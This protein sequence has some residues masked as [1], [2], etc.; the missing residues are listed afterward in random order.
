VA[1]DH[2]SLGTS[3]TVPPGSPPPEP[4]A[5][6]LQLDQFRA[7]LEARDSFRRDVEQQVDPQMKI[8]L[9]SDR[10]AID[11]AQG[12]IKNATILNGGALVAIPAIISFFGL[13][14]Q[15]IVW[16][17]LATGGLF[18]FGLI[19]AWLANI[20]GFFA[21]TARTEAFTSLANLMRTRVTREHY[22][23]DSRVETWKSEEAKNERRCN[24][25]LAR[26]HWWRIFGICCGLVSLALFVLGATWGGITVSVA[27]RKATM[28]IRAPA[29]RA[30]PVPS[31]PQTLTGAGARPAARQ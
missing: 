8:A 14:L 2:Y 18:I 16:P 17:L 1:Q 28:L 23:N 3:W 21:L 5:I 20:C 22:P 7:S 27:P 25:S 24:E 29:A 13:E 6:S 30:R 26:F 11:L 12:A 9:A 19:S 31:S 15:A 4:A 10:G